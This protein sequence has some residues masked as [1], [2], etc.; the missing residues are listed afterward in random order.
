MESLR[1][2]IMN[3]IYM[4]TIMFYKWLKATQKV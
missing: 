3:Y 1:A 4:Q 2:A